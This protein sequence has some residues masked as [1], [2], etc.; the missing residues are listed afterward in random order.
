[1]STTPEVK[2]LKISPAGQFD[3]DVA[4]SKPENYQSG[5]DSF[6]V[7]KKGEGQV[8]FRTVGWLQAAVI[9]LKGMS[10][11]LTLWMPVLNL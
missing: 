11:G 9:F 3:N 2:D 1:M 6:E 5:D 7:F 4:V 10:S 8:D